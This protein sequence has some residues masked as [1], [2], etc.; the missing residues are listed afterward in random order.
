MLGDLYRSRSV[1]AHRP[2]WRRLL[3]ISCCPGAVEAAGATVVRR[4]D[5]ARASWGGG[6]RHRRAWIH[7]RGCSG[8]VPDRWTNSIGFSS[9]L[10][11]GVFC[12]LPKPACDGAPFGLGVAGGVRRWRPAVAVAAGIYSS[13]WKGSRDLFV[14]SILLVALSVSRM[15]QL[16]SVFLYGV[17]VCVRFP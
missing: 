15:E 1:A 16:S 2:R 10:L 17:L 7:G 11:A 3:S 6:R 8:C 12:G 4:M 9:S 5:R 13:A 14:I